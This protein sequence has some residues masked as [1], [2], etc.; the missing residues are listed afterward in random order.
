[1]PLALQ[2]RFCGSVYVIQ[3]AGRIVIG[4][5]V[6][7]LEAALDH[8]AREFSRFVLDLS[9]VTRL[10]SMGLGLLVR[11]HT[12]LH[13]RGGD[14]RLAAP[15]DF[16]TTL[17]NL[18]KVSSVLHSY[19][20]EEEAILSFLKQHAAQR[21][22]EKRGIKL[23]MFDPSADLC[24]FVRTVLTQHGFD[25]RTTCSFRDAKILLKVDNVDY[26]LVGPGTPQLS[27][28]SV[29]SELRAMAPTASALQLAADFKS[30]DALEASHT[31]LQMLGVNSAS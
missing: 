21:S 6:I 15:P 28:E 3:C 5:E 4:E 14:L 27:S 2:S 20:T 16:V 18:T 24:A 10:D 19:P 25:V 29:A 11:H 26:I 22:E 23:L 12:R 13:K 31:L 9:Q 1:M 17:L 30:R 7:A 8:G